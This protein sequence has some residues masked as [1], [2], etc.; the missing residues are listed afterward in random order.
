LGL[1]EFNNYETFAKRYKVK[2]VSYNADN[3]AFHTETFQK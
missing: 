1:R 2:V 3:G